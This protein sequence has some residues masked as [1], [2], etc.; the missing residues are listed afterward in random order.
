MFIIRVTQSRVG[1]VGLVLALC[2]AAGCG[3][4]SLGKQHNQ[5][6]GAGVDAGE[7]DGGVGEFCEGP[8]KVELGSAVV[9][10]AVATSTR[11]VM[12]CCEGATLHLH[13]REA[14]GDDL[15]I[16]FRFAA[17]TWE[18]GTYV[19]D[20]GSGDESV[21]ATLADDPTEHPEQQISGFYILEQQDAEGLLPV[22][23][24][25]C[26]Q[27]TEPG[28]ALDGAAVFVNRQ[29]VASW[30]WTDRY[31][32][33]LLEDEGVTATQAATLPLA[34]LALRFQPLLELA[35]V[36]YYSESSHRL[37]LDA[38]YSGE[39]MANSL[40][41]LGTDGVPFVV[42]VDGERIYLGAFF[43]SLSSDGFD[44]PVIVVED[45]E[46][47]SFVIEPSYP[48]NGPVPEPDPR[49]DPRLMELFSSAGKLAP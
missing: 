3:G 22:L 25:A 10:S 46:Q 19:L 49:A 38:W 35:S 4:R 47:T 18:P 39:Y 13:T 30:N 27:V 5:G 16:S 21:I 15:K 44:G 20:G 32:L 26:L 33:W 12:D 42:T 41:A 37:G 28:D 24:S 7:L 6:D 9:T 34:S 14:L 8:N 2:L 31:G 29:P 45:V 43:T 36:A 48:G 11:L 40:P 1:A 17:A 23:M